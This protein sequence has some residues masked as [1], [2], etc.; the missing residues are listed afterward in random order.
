MG[1]SAEEWRTSVSQPRC[2]TWN[3]TKVDDEPG[4]CW[5][6]DT[7]SVAGIPYVHN[8]NSLEVTFDFFGDFW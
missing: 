2:R 3:A 4:R 8:H 1:F 6:V 5:L 7:F